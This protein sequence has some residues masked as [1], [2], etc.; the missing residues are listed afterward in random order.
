MG[1]HQFGENKTERLQIHF[2]VFMGATTMNADMTISI[3]SESKTM[4]MS[5]VDIVP[6]TIAMT[7]KNVILCA[8]TAT[9]FTSRK[10]S[11]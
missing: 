2:M 4:D 5:Y 9:A 7:P 3:A 10:T 8:S 11:S 1:D 6:T